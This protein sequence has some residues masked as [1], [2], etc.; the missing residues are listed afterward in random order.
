ML[1]IFRAGLVAAMLS[2]LAGCA[3]KNFVRPNYD[4][5]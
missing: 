5:F 4:T 2:L 1:P 3:E